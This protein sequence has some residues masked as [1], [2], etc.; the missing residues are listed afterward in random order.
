MPQDQL[1]S[2]GENLAVDYLISRKYRILERNFRNRIGELD[3]VASKDGMLCFIEVK[4]R[5]SEEYGDPL[6]AITPGKQRK[7]ILM[8]QSYLNA[9]G[10][11]DLQVR[12]D[13]MAVDFKN[14]TDYTI[15]FFEN[16]F[17]T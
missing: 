16:A 8:A 7:I 1:G 2:L 13:V 4:T 5:T 17:E 3:I 14:P 6:E 9:R 11:D 12:F 15:Q 10:L